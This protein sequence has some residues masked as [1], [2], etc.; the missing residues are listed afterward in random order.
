MQT[1]Q[2]TIFPMA[3]AQERLWIV[4]RLTPGTAAYH[5]PLAIRLTGTLDRAA[6]H[7]AVQAVVDRH[8]ALR[9]SFTQLDGVPVQVVADDVRIDLPVADVTEAGLEAALAEEAARPF[10]LTAR[11][12]LRTSLLRLAEDDHVWTVTLH[13]LVSDM[14]SCGILLDEVAVGYAARLAGQQ[15][16]LPELA[17]H[18]PDFTIWQRDRLTGEYRDRLLGHW[19][20]R[21][22]DAP[23]ITELPLDRPRPAAQSFRG[24]QV[25]VTLTP[26][27]SE[28]VRDLSRRS[29]VTPFMTLLAAFQLLLGRYSGQLDIVVATGAATRTPETERVVGCFINTVLLRTSLAG[30]PSFDE[31]LERVRA[32]TLDALDHQDLPFEQLV[33]A[34]QPQRDL[35][36]N[37]L[38]QVMF[39]LQNAPVPTVALPGLEAT[40]LAAERGGAQLDLDV[41][42]REV[43]GVFTG[44]VEYA[45][46]LFDEPTVRRMWQHYEVLLT[47]A[48]AEP[49]R[50]AGD[51]PLLT[52]EELERTVVE[53]NDTTA[54]APD[55]CLH[56]LFEEQAAARPDAPALAWTG[57]GLSYGELDARADRVARRLR[58]AG[59]GPDVRVAV[60]LDRSAA[61]AVAVLGVLKAGGAYVPLDAAYP[62]DRLAF[63]LQDA[64][65]AALVTD[66]ALLD[67]LPVDPA[68]GR[69]TGTDD[70]FTVPVLLTAALEGP[71]GPADAAPAS[72]AAQA[73]VRP[74]HLAYVIYTSGST[75]RP[76]GVAVTHRGV[77]NNIA[78]LNRGP[79]V[80]P[81]DSVLAL[82]SLSFDMSVYEL[83]GMLAAGGTTV[84][85]EADSA[86]DPRHWA[87]L[88]ERH[89]VTVWNS[90]PTLLEA[91]VA[92]YGDGRPARP[93]LRVAFLGGD[94]VPVPLPGRAR[95]LFPALDVVV[96]G[97]ATEASIHSIAQP[98]RE[99]GEEW[100]RI[101]Y[102]R[103]M[104]NQQALV[105][106]E[107]LR[108]VPVGVPGEL[109]L[110]GTGL[111][112]GYLD[113]PALTAE[114]F[115]P[116]PYAGL[117]PGVA[118]GA[119]LYR[120]G[121]LARYAADGTIHLIGRLDHQVKIR[122]HR[123]ELGE[124]DAALGRHPVVEEAVT[125]VR[126]GQ[127]GHG[128][129]LTA[130]VVPSEGAALTA[131]LLRDHLRA[132]LPDHMVPDTY[133][134]LDAL[135][136]SANGKIDRRGLTDADGATPLAPSTAY[137]APATV[138]ER[139]VAGIWTTV[140]DVDRIGVHDD[141][142]E[143]GGNSLMVTQ[144]AAVLASDLRVDVP[145][146]ALF[147]TP[148]V[149]GQ[150]ALAEAAGLRAGVDAAAVADL[151]LQV[152]ALDGAQTQDLLHSLEETNR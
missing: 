79:S 48:L 135:P 76:K 128:V 94:W 140:L 117:G 44:F 67:R 61:V 124:V 3:S 102:G 31:L 103:P 73:P 66:P 7:A 56:Q 8:E 55:R 34:L 151:Y 77:V 14:W 36:V 19:R 108:A 105:V 12:L 139:A 65:P 33:A 142:F 53:W 37:P 89:S 119:R 114:R 86:K 22:A 74:G 69:V 95:A 149:A 18:Y 152:R 81:G 130:Y 129:G 87:E 123:I 106:D 40:V 116:H 70:A 141:F 125:V 80:G 25:P 1:S 127:Q 2:P 13:H 85:P 90:A 75:G 134:A 131:G 96:M 57:G 30:D 84:L 101:P 71:D 28:A 49:G 118:P 62:A 20:D 93:T 43:G 100:T 41:Q 99:T 9:T 63:M 110:A 88:I 136:L 45:E 150:A 4:E 104:A 5:I 52:A 148:T 143:R 138:L 46:D 15:S 97:G 144:V 132:T 11:P 26:A 35:S 122:G 23:R 32:T 39:I 115:V 47:A 60:C 42:L 147:E 145:L 16:E 120:T 58:A 82:S 50:A 113:R 51:L 91:L 112:R 54:P 29:G 78:D 133:V 92:S 21:L 137:V 126:L 68:T 109:C 107:H 111:A 17:L 59:V 24:R 38:A 98:V 83:L 10:D 72:G 146:R 27:L 121:D 6:L 64:R